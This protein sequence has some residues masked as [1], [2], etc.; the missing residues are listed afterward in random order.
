MNNNWTKILE[1][2]NA[3]Y[4]ELLKKAQYARED[5]LDAS[6]VKPDDAEYAEKCKQKSI[7]LTQMAR[8]ARRDLTKW[9]MTDFK[10]VSVVVNTN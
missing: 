4:E 10:I 7:V 8:D 2:K 5:E 3:I 6:T 9:M 1:E